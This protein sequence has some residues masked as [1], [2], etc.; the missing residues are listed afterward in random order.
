MF[1]KLRFEMNQ[2]K[3]LMILE[4]KPKDNVSVNSDIRYNDFLTGG[5][6]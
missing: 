5:L 1:N 3:S 4:S 6:S 2:D